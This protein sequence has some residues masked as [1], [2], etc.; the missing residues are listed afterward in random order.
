MTF[1]LEDIDDLEVGGFSRQKIIFDLRIELRD[2]L[3][4]FHL[5][6][7]YG[8]AGTIALRKVSIEFSPGK[9]AD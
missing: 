5:D 8:L 3:L 7:C 2:G 6:P 1:L 9:P 4:H